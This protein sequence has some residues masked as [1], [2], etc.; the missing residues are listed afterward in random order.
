M[1]PYV[2]DFIGSLLGLVFGV[3]WVEWRARRDRATQARLLR[4][5][6]VK[7]CKFA[8]GGIDKCLEF[9][10]KE[11]KVPNVRLDSAS[12]GHILFT[13]R[14][15]F[16]NP[17]FFEDFNWQRYQLDHIN[18]KL[19]YFHFYMAASGETARSLMI[20]ERQSLVAH[21]RTT[22]KEL[23]DLVDSFEQETNE[24]RCCK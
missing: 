14:D 19:D 12:I 3:L 13:G 20:A 16:E 15:L 2:H 8:L 6:L 22:R 10:L 9:L 23:G 5:N 17:K 7:A 4:A 24:M 11:S 18:A 1:E 21:L